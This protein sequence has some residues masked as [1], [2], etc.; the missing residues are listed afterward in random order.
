MPQ[1]GCTQLRGWRVQGSDPVLWKEPVPDSDVG[2]EGNW[3]AQVSTRRGTPTL[4]AGDKRAHE[5]GKVGGPQ[6]KC[7]G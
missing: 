5:P 1:A 2:G 6:G 3:A 4:H 7:C